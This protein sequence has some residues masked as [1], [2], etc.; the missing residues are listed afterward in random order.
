MINKVI[1]LL[2]NAGLVDSTNDKIILLGL[3]RIFAALT[4]L[5]IAMVWAMILGDLFVG[6]L[7]EV[8]YSVL[9]IY[10]GGFHAKDEKTCKYL[11][12]TSTLVCVF[13]VFTWSLNDIYTM[14]CLVIGLVA[15]ILFNAPIENENKPLA[16]NEK[17]IYYLYCIGISI[18][19]LVVYF[20]FVQNEMVLYARTVCIA[21]L[22]VVVG[23]LGEIGRQYNQPKLP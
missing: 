11:T 10:V 6:I 23:V 7:F 16:K 4:D 2:R 14:H 3:R 22:L 1:E 18:A 17:K 13:V 8:C 12:Y 5:F 15:V 9:R 21:I 19:E 20:L